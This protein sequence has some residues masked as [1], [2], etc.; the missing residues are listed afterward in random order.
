[1]PKP[2]MAGITLRKEVAELLRTKAKEAN[3]G[4]NEFLETTLIGPSQSL[5]ATTTG[6]SED[7]PRTVL[8]DIEEQV[9]T[10][11]QAL[12]QETSPNQT[13]NNAFSLSEGSLSEKRKFLVRAPR[14]EPGSSAWQADVLDQTRLRPQVAVAQRTLCRCPY[15]A[16]LNMT[17]KSNLCAK[18]PV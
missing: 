11:P 15:S 8:Q 10:L 17:F 4:L 13:Q 7:S 6:P 9:I 14:F 1:M 3:M 18:I 5:Q 12:N 16:F 2:G